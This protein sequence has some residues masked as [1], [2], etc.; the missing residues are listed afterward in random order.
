ML[1]V[2]IDEDTALDMLTERVEF[3]NDDPE[4]VHLFTNYYENCI[5]GGV[6]EGSE[7]DVMSIVDNDYVNYTQHGTLDEIRDM[8]GDNFDEDNIL[9]RYNDLILYYAC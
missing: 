7:F 2:T 8:F 1:N 3:W 4:V 6:F 9:A 5:D